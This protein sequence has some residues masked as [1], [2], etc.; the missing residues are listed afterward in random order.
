MT[1][2]AIRRLIKQVYAR[3]PCK[4]PVLE[5][6]RRTVRLPKNLTGHLHFRGPFTVEIDDSHRF[7]LEHWGYM[8]ENDLFWNGFGNGY[9]GTS[10]LVWSRL[11]PHAQTIVDVG[12][13]TGV[14]A[15]AARCLNPTATVV[16]LEPVVR[17]FRRLQRNVEL[18][19]GKVAAENLAASDTTGTAVI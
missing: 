2:P 18:N 17:V 8:V 3:V 9:E 15:L 1:A 14:Y 4:Q 5:I 12:A 10:L 19:G 7:R 13:N 11:A 6:L 16:A